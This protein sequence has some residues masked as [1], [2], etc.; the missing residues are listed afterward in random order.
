MLNDLIDDLP[1]SLEAKITGALAPG[2]SAIIKLRGALKEALICTDRR[3]LIIKSGFGTGSTFGVNLF[4]LAYQNITSVEV[5]F[6]LV[7]GY[8]EISTGGVQNTRKT[9][10]TTDPD[11]NPSRSPNCVGLN[12]RCDKSRFDRACTYIMERVHKQRT[13]APDT[14]MRPASSISD[15]LR[16]ADLYERGLLTEEEF[17]S[18]KAKL[19]VPDTGVS[20]DAL[21]MERVIRPPVPDEEAPLPAHWEA[22]LQR[23]AARLNNTKQA[24]PMLRTPPTFGRR[25]TRPQA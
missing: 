7:S 22:A 15:V 23:E 25:V 1:G 11:K 12:L 10:W 21:V 20:D 6:G 8:F 16:L 2:E 3:V 4:Q 19:M 14:S 9:I 5:K 18:E 24:D 13:G 17:R